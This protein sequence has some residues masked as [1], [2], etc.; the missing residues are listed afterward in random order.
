M[1]SVPTYIQLTFYYLNGQT[2]S[3][4]VY[5]PIDTGL[6]EQEIQQEMR[7]YLD[8]PWWI[9]HLSDRTIY[10]NVANIYKVEIT[11]SMHLLQGDGVFQNAERLGN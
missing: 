11:P 9:L 6:I 2:E 5:D 8:R 7:R 10:V 3:Y 4:K 1:Q